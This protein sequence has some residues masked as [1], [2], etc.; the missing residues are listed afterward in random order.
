VRNSYF[1]DES[2]DQKNEQDG[3]LIAPREQRTLWQPKARDQRERE[4]GSDQNA[5]FIENDIHG[6]RRDPQPF[7]TLPGRALVP[8]SMSL[9]VN[10]KLAH[11][12]EFEHQQSDRELKA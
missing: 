2:E 4:C 1:F 11:A 9:L 6:E 12:V 10:S 8:E 7:F 5:N 3:S